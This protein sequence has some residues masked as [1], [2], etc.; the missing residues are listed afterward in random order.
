MSSKP[1]EDKFHLEGGEVI[2]QIT[3]GMNDGVVSIFALLA[4]VAG[5]GQ[6]PKM[7]LVTLLAATIAGALSM[8]AGEYISGKSESQFFKHE[9]E[10][11]RIEI[12][13]TPEIEKEEVRLIY[14]KKGFQGELLD[15]IVHQ[16]IQDKDRWVREMVIE[17][18]GV[19]DLDQETSLKEP[20]IIFFAFILGALFPVLPYLLFQ[21]LWD[22]TVIFWIAT[23]L[24]FGGLFMAGALKKFVTGAIWWKSGIEMLIVGLFAYG[25]SYFIGTLVGVA[26]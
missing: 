16:I 24:T 18:L 8:S 20:I 9:I 21:S 1:Y 10:Q 12:E 26:I 13:L 6:S 2:R 11:E 19:T 3:F 23:G 4:G 7:I 17:E 5:A 22:G 15:K 14:Q 25:V